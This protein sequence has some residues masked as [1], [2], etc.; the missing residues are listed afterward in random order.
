MNLETIGPPEAAFLLAGQL[1]FR[2]MNSKE[3]I[4][5]VLESD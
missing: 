1:H 2:H 4:Q 5:Q 3:P